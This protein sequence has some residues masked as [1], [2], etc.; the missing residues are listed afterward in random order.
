M[1]RL[2]RIHEITAQNIL[3]MQEKCIPKKFSSLR[4]YFAELRVRIS[5]TTFP[6]LRTLSRFLQK[7]SGLM[8]LQ[9][10]DATQ[11]KLSSV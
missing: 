6:Q 3:I 5:L 8:V 1:P 11:Y 10:K 4:I 7:A 2:L 9:P